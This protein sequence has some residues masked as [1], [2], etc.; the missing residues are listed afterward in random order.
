[1][2]MASE[3]LSSTSGGVEDMSAISRR[4]VALFSRIALMAGVLFLLLWPALSSAGTLSAF[5]I[6]SQDTLRLHL[7]LDSAVPN[8]NL[9]TLDS[10]D[11][12][13]IDLPG[14]SLAASLSAQTFADGLVQAVRY[15]CLLYTSPSPRDRQK[16]RMPSSA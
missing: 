14:T 10:P 1:M 7:D 6:V 4:V 12:L 15:G 5:R 11:R 2:L 9:F 13:V 8:A 16:S 3:A